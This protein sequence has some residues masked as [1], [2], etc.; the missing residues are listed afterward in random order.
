MCTDAIAT[1]TAHIFTQTAHNISMEHK[2]HDYQDTI[3]EAAGIEND[4][5]SVAKREA[6]Q[7]ALLKYETLAVNSAMGM[8]GMEQNEA[9][10]LQLEFAQELLYD[11][12][13]KENEEGDND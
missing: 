5:E 4:E 11:L 7:D 6:K 2:T 12:N 1:D 10:I 8:F 9:N 13:R 3:N